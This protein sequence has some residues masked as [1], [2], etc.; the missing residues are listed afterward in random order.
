[1]DVAAASRGHHRV[2]QR[3]AID[4]GLPEELESSDVGLRAE[5]EALSGFDATQ[6]AIDVEVDEQP[7]LH[8]PALRHIGLHHRH[9]LLVEEHQAASV[10][11]EQQAVLHP[12]TAGRLIEQ[13]LHA[14]LRVAFEAAVAIN[15]S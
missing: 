14:A 6:L 13:P 1:E 2:A 5:A 4:H 15:E 12:E 7:I 3:A 10:E 11:V 8:L 9:A